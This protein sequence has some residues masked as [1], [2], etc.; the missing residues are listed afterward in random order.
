MCKQ[1]IKDD[2]A[3]YHRDMKDDPEYRQKAAV[4]A[5][6]YYIR[7]HYNLSEEDFQQ[8]WDKQDGK[9]KICERPFEGTKKPHI[10][11]DHE[12]GAF[13]GLLCGRCNAALGLL[14]EDVKIFRSAIKYLLT[15]ARK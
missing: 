12:T 10:D 11:H 4:R 1:C 6:N 13:R 15:W 3:K 7:V 2:A 14:R 9:C 5:R 8:A